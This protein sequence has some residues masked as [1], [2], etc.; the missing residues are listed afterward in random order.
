MIYKILAEYIQE[1]LV[2]CRFVGIEENTGELFVSFD[3]GANDHLKVKVTEHLLDKFDGVKKIIIVERVDIRKATE[4][5]NE[6]NE[7]LARRGN[8]DLI[9][10]EGL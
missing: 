3:D 5:V 8:P 10:I 4:M 7:I 6:L 2:G 9:K 1:H